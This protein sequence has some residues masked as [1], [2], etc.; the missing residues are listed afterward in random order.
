MDRVQ[1]ESLE[2]TGRCFVPSER[3]VRGTVGTG[4]QAWLRLGSHL[5]VVPAPPGCVTQGAGSEAAGPAGHLRPG[6]SVGPGEEPLQSHSWAGD[7]RSLLSSAP[8]G[9]ECSGR[10]RPSQGAAGSTMWTEGAK[11]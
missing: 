10:G 4:G 8:Q 5:W 7:P 1:A 3:T 9:R 6:S 11:A 2:D